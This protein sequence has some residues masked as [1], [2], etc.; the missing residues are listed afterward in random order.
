MA[1]IGGWDSTA[2]LWD[3]A[4]GELC[5]T[6]RHTEG[7]SA[8]TLAEMFHLVLVRDADTAV[9][10]RLGGAPFLAAVWRKELEERLGT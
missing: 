7:G 4:T 10:Q 1:G 2:R 3:A 6:L 8:I 9:L 5:A